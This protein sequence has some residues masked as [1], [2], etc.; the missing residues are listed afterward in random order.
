MNPT[1]RIVRL[2]SLI[3]SIVAFTLISSIG[4]VA[5][6]DSPTP[7]TTLENSEIA[8]VSHWSIYVMDADGLGA[9]C[10]T[11]C[12]QKIARKNQSFAPAWSHDGRQIAFKGYR[13]DAD[14]DGWGIFVMNAD[15]SNTHRLADYTMCDPE[16][17]VDPPT[18]SPDDLHIAFIACQQEGR[19]LYVMDAD[20]SNLKQLA[21]IDG[22]SPAWSPN[23]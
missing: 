20:G 11:I 7:T 12:D 6:A 17:I 15:G 10:L 16:P 14:N 22:W 1:Q 21:K 23:G 8:Y 5:H 4:A 19:G 3:A 13:A 2:V 18:W 9:R